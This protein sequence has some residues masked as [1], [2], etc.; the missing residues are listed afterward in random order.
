LIDK[1]IKILMNCRRRCIAVLEMVEPFVV[2]LADEKLRVTL[3]TDCGTDFLEKK[4]E[5]NHIPCVYV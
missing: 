5:K 3:P 1:G 2:G 4:N